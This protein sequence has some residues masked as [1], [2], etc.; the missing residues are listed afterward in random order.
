MIVILFQ[1]V[2]DDSVFHFRHRRLESG[3]SDPSL[4]HMLKLRLSPK[5]SAYH[6]LVY[7]YARSKQCDANF[8]QVEN[9]S[10]MKCEDQ[11]LQASKYNILESEP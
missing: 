7:C 6:E 10:A 11:I 5:V 1:V 8:S 3:S 2:G 4:L 9:S